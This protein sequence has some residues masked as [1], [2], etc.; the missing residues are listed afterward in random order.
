MM[1]PY[2]THQPLLL[3]CAARVRA[4]Q[5]VLELG[6]GDY[7]TRQLH[8]VCYRAR[9]LTVERDRDWLE[10]YADCVSPRHALRHAGTLVTTLAMIRTVRRWELALVDSSPAEWRAPQIAT[11]ADRARWIVI[12]DTED[13]VYRYG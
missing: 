1:D 8:A 11:L 3:A 6:A 10:Q 13:P 4:H 9:I 12:H 7:S 5:R 2:G